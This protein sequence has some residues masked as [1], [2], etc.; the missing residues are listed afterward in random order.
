MDGYVLLCQGLSVVWALSVA[1]GGEMAPRGQTIYG[2]IQV[3]HVAYSQES[4]TPGV[5]RT[6]RLQVGCSWKGVL[7]NMRFGTTGKP[8]GCPLLGLMVDR[9]P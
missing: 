7:A 5:A 6:R 3:G 1:S 4:E 9:G 8:W 2:V